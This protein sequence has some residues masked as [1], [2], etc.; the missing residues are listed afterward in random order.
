MQLPTGGSLP[1]GATE[2]GFQQ[3]ARFFGDEICIIGRVHLPTVSAV[4]GWEKESALSHGCHGRSRVGRVVRRD[5]LTNQGVMECAERVRA[6]GASQGSAGLQALTWD[7][8]R[9]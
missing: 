7:H 3:D 9:E 4:T 8:S 6:A 2:G 5:E 1:Q